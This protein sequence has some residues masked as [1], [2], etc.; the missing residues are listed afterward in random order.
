MRALVVSN[1]RQ[2]SAHPARGSFVRDQVAAL[3][4]I[5][6]LEVDLVEGLPGGR[7]YV[8]LA[9]ELRGRRGYDVVHVHFGLTGYPALVVRGAKRAITLHGTDVRHPRTGRLTRAVLPRYDLV[10][11]ASQ[12]LADELDR[13]GVAVLP[14]GADLHRLRPEP[15]DEARARLGLVPAEGSRGR[16]GAGPGLRDAAGS[17][18]GA[19]PAEGTD[20]GLRDAAGA[21]P[22]GGPAEGPGL[23]DSA[24]ARAG[25]ESGEWL[26]LFPA[27]P[28]RAGK[29]VDRARELAG[30]VGARLITLGSTPP[31]QMRDWIN[32]CDAVLVPSE[33]EGFGLAVVEALACETPVL[34]TPVGIHPQALDG[35]P[36][37]LCG[38]Y[39]RSA[40]GA[41]LRDVLAT[42]GTSVEGG[43]ERAERWSSDAMAA[44]VADA[45]RGI[46]APSPQIDRS[47]V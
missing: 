9:R 35:L 7:G 6:G 46:C 30:D 41:M 23:R 37:T 47:R 12:E 10:A 8:D 3:R 29:R 36:H 27:D 22:G 20:A 28:A 17:A 5:D 4:R 18:P 39:D 26:L 38:V 24:R 2:D 11:A 32:A 19:G 45:W 21:S 1:M 43:R 16:A 44:R 25:G 33:A 34:A 31:E 15:R 42:P 40:W 14:C 13:P